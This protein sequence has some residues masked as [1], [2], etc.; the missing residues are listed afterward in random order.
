MCNKDQR[1]LLDEVTAKLDRS[2]YRPYN[3]TK[4]EMARLLSALPDRGLFVP[5][6]QPAYDVRP[7]GN[8]RVFLF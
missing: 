7:N 3:R 8:T 2:Y 1:E 5:K 6:D 4:P